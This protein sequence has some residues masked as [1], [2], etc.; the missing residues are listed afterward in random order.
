MLK[1]ASEFVIKP[2]SGYVRVSTT[3]PIAF[4]LLVEIIGL[5]LRI[6]RFSTS[7]AEFVT[8]L[9]EL[10]LVAFLA[11]LSLSSLLSL[12]GHN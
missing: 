12:L 3:D 1:V 9:S 5:R 11:F 7:L 4:K 2:L 10:L 8:L 6:L